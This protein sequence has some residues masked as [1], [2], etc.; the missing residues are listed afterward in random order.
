MG[1]TKSFSVPGAGEPYND[2]FAPQS[3]TSP[4][5]AEIVV[6]LLCHQNHQTT[7]FNGTPISHV[8]GMIKDFLN[9]VYVV[10][11][12]TNI[13]WR[14]WDI[15]DAD[16]VLSRDT[17][18]QDMRDEFDVAV[19][20]H[21]RFQYDDILPSDFKT[22]CRLLKP[23]GLLIVPRNYESMKRTLE[24]KEQYGHPELV[25]SE[26]TGLV[27]IFS[28]RSRNSNSNLNARPFTS[29]RSDGLTVFQKF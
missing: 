12:H 13:I 11:P 25:C 27:P 1:N 28:E 2:V 15:E 18:M 4:Y 9:D 24:I 14:T 7:A 29:L 23:Q 6:A 19:S 26:N 17:Y 3:S 8:K 16:I 22:M 5:K 10:G 21:C 20:M